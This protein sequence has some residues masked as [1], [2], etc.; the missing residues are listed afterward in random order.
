VQWLTCRVDK[1]PLLGAAFSGARAPL[2]EARTAGCCLEFA[3]AAALG[4]TAESSA[5]AGQ[6]NVACAGAPPLIV[7]DSRFVFP[8]RLASIV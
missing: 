2:A 6:T 3:A 1:W 8:S 4:Q 5:P 7:T